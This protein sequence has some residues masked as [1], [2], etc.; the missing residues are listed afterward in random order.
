MTKA[1][2]HILKEALALD[3]DDLAD[4]M[5]QLILSGPRTDKEYT[6]AW[7]EEIKKRLEEHESGKV[8][9]VPWEEAAER[10]FGKK[11]KNA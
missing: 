5:D 3:P 4:L 10:I 6:T 9:A 8:K 2:E 7:S 1:A 11:D